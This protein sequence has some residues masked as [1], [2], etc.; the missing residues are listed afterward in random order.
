MANGLVTVVVDGNDG[1]FSVDGVAGYGKLVDGGD[2]GDS[3]NYSPPAGD[4]VVDTPDTVH[5]RRW[6]IAARCGPWS[7]WWRT[8]PGPTTSTA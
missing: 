8:T 5:G 2:H 7:R 3:Y 4:A 6:A 1:T